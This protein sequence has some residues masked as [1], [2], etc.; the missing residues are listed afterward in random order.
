MKNKRDEITVLHTENKNQTSAITLIA[1]V[2]TIVILLIL[3]AVTISSFGENGLFS[4]AKEARFKSKISAYKEQANTYVSW[5]IS[6]TMK[7]DTSWINSGEVLKDAI[8]KGIVT[9]IKQ[10]D[11]S[12]NIEDIL[13]DINKNEKEYI[14]IYKGELCYVSSENIKNNK[15]YVKWCEEIGIRILEYTKEEGIVIKNGKYELVTGIY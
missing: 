7:T 13:E 15:N 6:E 10:D 3:A 11:V 2:I 12:I 4:R 14:V 9:D 8:D 1:L 5:Q